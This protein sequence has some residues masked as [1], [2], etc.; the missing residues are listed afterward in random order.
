MNRTKAF[1][2]VKMKAELQDNLKKEYEACKDS[3]LS[4]ADFIREEP[5]LSDELRALKDKILS[6]GAKP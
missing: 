4:Y 6:A 1:D 5:L 3:G 2:C